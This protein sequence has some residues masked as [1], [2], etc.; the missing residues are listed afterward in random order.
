M[1]EVDVDLNIFSKIRSL[2]CVESYIL[3]ILSSLN[4]EYKHLY[5]NS[6]ASFYDIAHFFL[7]EKKRYAYFDCIPRIQ[8]TAEACEII[9][10][11]SYNCSELGNIVNS[12]SYYL[13]NVKPNYITTRYGVA[14]WRDDHYM[15]LSSYDKVNSKLSYIND[16]PR[17]CGTMNADEIL[18]AYNKGI[19]QIKLLGNINDLT[20]KS[21]YM[22]FCKSLNH[23][24]QSYQFNE[25]DD[26]LSARDLVGILRILRYRLF[27]YYSLFIECDFM[28]DYLKE[29]DRKYSII[30][31]KRQRNR[32]DYKEIVNMLSTLQ[33]MD[34]ENI[35]KIK[36]KMELM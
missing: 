32:V 22:D 23:S 24:D 9:S 34:K 4:Y 26:I 3:Y 15:L 36:K 20:K 7:D 11:N 30:E 18:E 27:E 5:A 17:D 13:F 14:M 33:D 25:I 8:T 12:D 2:S 31:Y 10:M 28:V 1:I 21:L 29:L 16:N 19:I 6:Y 35:D